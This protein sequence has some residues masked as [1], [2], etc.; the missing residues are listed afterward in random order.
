MLVALE[1]L[2]RIQLIFT[3]AKHRK[4]LPLRFD[5]E[6]EPIV[7]QESHNNPTFLLRFHI[8]NAHNMR[9]ESLVWAPT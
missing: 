5:Q 6:P 8:R 9:V 7:L 2:G 3:E 4:V 1:T